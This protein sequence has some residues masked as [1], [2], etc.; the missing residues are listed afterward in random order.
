VRG[1]ASQRRAGRWL[2][3]AV[4]LILVMLPQVSAACPVCF[5]GVEDDVRVAFILTTAFMTFLPLLMVGG[6][7]WW[8]VRHTLQREREYDALR[9]QQAEVGSKVVGAAGDA[10][11]RGAPPSLA[12]V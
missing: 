12:R 3:T 5:G 2:I 6:V 4:A 11:E 8:F 7:I 1:W 9:A 10:G